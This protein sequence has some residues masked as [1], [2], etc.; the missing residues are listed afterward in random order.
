MMATDAV[1]VLREQFGYETF[2][3][4]QER[5]VRAVLAGRDIVN[6]TLVDTVGISSIAGNS[7]VSQSLLG[8]QGTIASTG[9]MVIAAGNDLMV[10]G[11]NIAAG[12]N[13]QIGAG[14]DITVDTVQSDTSQSVTKN[15]QHHWEAS[16]TTNQTSGTNDVTL[17]AAGNV[18]ITTS[19][20]MQSTQSDY[21]KRE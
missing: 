14:H 5:A 20:D 1:R 4:G 19:Q 11:A 9:D 21:Q 18:N 16:S 15:D 6:T 3:P 17:A 7:K 8:A 10:H 13:A 12:G 2:R